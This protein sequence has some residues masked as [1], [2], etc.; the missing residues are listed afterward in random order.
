MQRNNG[1]GSCLMT[2]VIATLAFLVWALDA[3]GQ[4]PYGLH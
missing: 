3:L 1:S 2:F 4:L